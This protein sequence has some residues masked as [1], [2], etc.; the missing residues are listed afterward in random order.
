MKVNNLALAAGTLGLGISEFGMMGVLPDVAKDLQISIPEAAHFISF[1]A[2]GVCVGAPIMV[3][4]GRKIPYKKLLIY[5]VG[6]IIFGNL[7]TCLSFSYETLA[8][9]RFIAGLP[10]GAYFGVAAIVASKL[11]DVGKQSAAVAMVLSGMTVANLLGIPLCTFLGDVFSWRITY[12]AVTIWSFIT[13]I[14]INKWIPIIPL[15]VITNFS[16]QFTF[17]KNWK[18]WVLILI[19]TFGNGGIF[20]WFS[21]VSKVMTNVSGFNQAHLGNIMFLAGIGMFLGNI[22]SGKMS[23]RFSPIKVVIF[24]QAL[25]IVGLISVFYLSH[26]QSIALISLLLL[27][28]CLFGLSAPEQVL[29]LRNSEGGQM[30]GASCAQIAFNLG[31]AIG[32]LAGGIPITK[33]FTYNYTAIPGIVISSLGLLLL[34]FFYFKTQKKSVK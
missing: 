33:G 16:S 2:A 10:H 4:L 7:L 25:A 27:T 15:T 9:S 3:I 23:D 29:L 19:I 22:L 13:I 21:Y 20:C 31:N 14:L 30:L 1:Y 24:I 28:A 32:A 17:L 8:A 34:L 18:P 12:I 5:L 6:L 26:L 11:S